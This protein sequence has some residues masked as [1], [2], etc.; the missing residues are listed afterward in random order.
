MGRMRGKLTLTLSLAGALTLAF[1]A[2]QALAATLV[3]VSANPESSELN[4]DDQTNDNDTITVSES[5]G[6][7]TVTDTGT[8]GA[9]A[10]AGCA[11][12][13]A[14][15]VTCPTDPAD[16]APPAPPTAPIRDIDLDLD[17]GTDSFLNE[18]FVVDV[19]ESD[20]GAAGPKTV[21]SGPGDDSISTGT[22]NDSIDTGTGDDFAGTDPGEDTITTGSG[23]DQ[24]FAEDGNDT[25]DT[26]EGQDFVEEGSFINGADTLNG[27]P[28]AQDQMGYFGENP[29]TITLNGQAD[30][31][32]AGEGDNVLGFEDLFSGEGNDV[33]V[34]DDAANDLSANDGDDL[35]AGAGGDDDISQGDGNDGVDAGEGNDTVFAGS[36]NDGADLLA[37]AGGP[38]DKVDYCCGFEPV[39]INQNGQADDGRAGEGDNLSGFEGF[40]GGDGPDSILADGSANMIS[41]NGGADSLVGNGGGDEFFAGAGDDTVV[42]SG[43]SS[44]ARGTALVRALAPRDELHCDL[45]TEFAGGQEGPG[46]DTVSADAR[47]IVGA[48]CERAGAEIASDSARVNKKGKA[49]VRVSCPQEE[50]AQCN[51]KL[52]LLS[53][54]KQVGKGKYKIANGKEKNVTA[55]LSKKGRKA[56]KQSKGTLLVSA[57]AR[58]REPPGVTANADDLLL[59]QAKKGGGKR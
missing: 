28:G 19:N 4:I 21:S 14:N 20:G 59:T 24:V 39:N 23:N 26:G 1:G 9:T 2:G 15:T 57:E 6:T 27:G 49:K 16:P 58:T 22:G 30:D 18:N 8:G 48:D 7:I 38:G 34:G 5:G 43:G 40:E 32:H 45:A 44:I 17:T 52:V 46:F 47:D 41:G 25:V 10:G 51:G 36:D 29:V 55:K 12:V 11:P 3:S 54:Q 31:G 33:L 37:G 42:S 13:N 56:L 50:G 35:I 53:N